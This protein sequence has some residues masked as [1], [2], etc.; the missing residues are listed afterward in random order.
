MVMRKQYGK[1]KWREDTRAH[2]MLFT[3][4]QVSANRDQAERGKKE[5]R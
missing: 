4:T 5:Q 2:T 1:T 3:V